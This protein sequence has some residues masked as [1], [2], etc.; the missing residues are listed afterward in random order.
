M[1]SP[2]N[3]KKNVFHCPEK[4]RNGNILIQIP[5]IIKIVYLLINNYFYYSY[6]HSSSIKFSPTL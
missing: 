1:Q 4:P 3:T 5:K 2:D 6:S